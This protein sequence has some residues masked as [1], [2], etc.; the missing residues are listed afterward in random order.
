MHR[1]GPLQAGEALAGNQRQAWP[2]AMSWGSAS[3]VAA[4]DLALTDL[5]VGRR[6][7]GWHADRSADQLRAQAQNHREWEAQ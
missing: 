4:L 6:P 3:S 7:Q 1:F 2:G 5:R